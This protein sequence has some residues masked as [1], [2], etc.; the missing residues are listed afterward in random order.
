MIEYLPS[1]REPWV[2]SQ[3][4]SE[5]GMVAQGLGVRPEELQLKV[6]LS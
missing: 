2:S 4:Y 5:T 1:R 3:Q 6:I